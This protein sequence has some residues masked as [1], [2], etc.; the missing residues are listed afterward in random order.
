MEGGTKYQLVPQGQEYL[1]L[2]DSEDN[3]YVYVM[4][5]KSSGNILVPHT[6]MDGGSGMGSAAVVN[7]GIMPQ[8]YIPVQAVS[9]LS[10]SGTYIQGEQGTFIQGEHGATAFH[11]GAM[12]NPIHILPDSSQTMQLVQGAVHSSAATH[13][14]GPGPIHR[15]TGAMHS[16][17]ATVNNLP[18]SMQN[19]PVS[20]PTGPPSMISVTA[21]LPSCGTV[22]A[23][24]DANRIVNNIANDW[25]SDNE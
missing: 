10:S 15:G 19:V 21:P 12:D 18:L 6:V 14:S 17:P 13:L 3:K 16:V 8:T 4:D 5:L 1:Q 20:V 25:D 22:S 23:A 7:G 9:G 24:I 2:L 11:H